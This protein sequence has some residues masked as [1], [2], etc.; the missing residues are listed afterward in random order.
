MTQFQIVGELDSSYSEE[1]IQAAVQAVQEKAARL[2]EKRLR[3]AR[4]DFREGDL[5]LT[6]RGIGEITDADRGLNCN[7]MEYEIWDFD[8]LSPNHGCLYKSAHKENIEDLL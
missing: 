3:F 4:G 6:A 8:H 2:V 5:V 7:E 1:E